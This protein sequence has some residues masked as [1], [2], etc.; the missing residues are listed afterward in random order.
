[1]GL[2]KAIPGKRYTAFVLVYVLIFLL[3]GGGRFY[4]VPNISVFMAFPLPFILLVQIVFWCYKSLHYCFGLKPIL[5]VLVFVLFQAALFLLQRIGFLNEIFIVGNVFFFA[6]LGLLTLLY[7]S[8][9]LPKKYK[10][11]AAMVVSFFTLFLTEYGREILEVAFTSKG[12]LDDR[13]IVINHPKKLYTLK[14]P[15]EHFFEEKYGIHPTFGYY[16]LF[17]GRQVQLVADY[18]GKSAL[19]SFDAYFQLQRIQKN[20][21]K[22][23]DN[24]WGLEV[25]GNLSSSPLFVPEDK[26]KTFVFDCWGAPPIELNGRCLRIPKN[27]EDELAFRY[28]L[29]PGE[30]KNWKEIES[31]IS[32]RVYQF[33][34]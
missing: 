10:I 11:I 12:I 3:L 9:I 21:D 1:M 33:V 18:S 28:W 25:Y 26:Q 23:K 22:I 2:F 34:Q 20:G 27:K 13:E 17:L 16:E 24:F 5:G 19:S 8:K 14:L 6:F 32:N 7:Y 31:N 4:Y 15:R 30:L 29:E